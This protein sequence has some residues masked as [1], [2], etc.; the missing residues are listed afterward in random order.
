V[1]PLSSPAR[2]GLAASIVVV[3]PARRQPITLQA[4]VVRHY[5]EIP[6]CRRSKWSP[7]K[8]VKSARSGML[9]NS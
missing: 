5:V 4:V 2:S 8:R 3:D 6:F 1:C 7:A 9:Q